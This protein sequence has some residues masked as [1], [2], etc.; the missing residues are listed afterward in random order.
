M[1]TS[2]WWRAD[3][4]GWRGRESL[5]WKGEFRNS[6]GHGSSP[7]YSDDDVPCAAELASSA[8]R[9]QSFSSVSRGSTN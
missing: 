5:C 3:S 9:G 6:M 4:V 2:D 8:P 7:P 1:E